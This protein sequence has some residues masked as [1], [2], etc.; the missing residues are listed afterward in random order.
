MVNQ[1][2]NH[3]SIIAWSL[4]NEGGDGPN[5]AAS[6]KWVHQRDPTRPVHYERASELASSSSSRCLWILHLC[7]VF[8]SSYTDIPNVMYELPHEVALRGQEMSKLP[9]SEQV[10]TLPL[11]QGL[12]FLLT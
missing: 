1:N 7:V 10:G 2:L 12:L 9:L 11:R 5:F 8:A 3:P 6:A 4:G